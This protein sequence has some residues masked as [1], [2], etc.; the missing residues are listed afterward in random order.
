MSIK[1]NFL[2]SQ[3]L[4]YMEIKATITSSALSLQRKSNLRI[5]TSPVVAIGT[6]LKDTMR[7]KV[8]IMPQTVRQA[9][10]TFKVAVSRAA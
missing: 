3:P 9:A 6:L 1:S 10:D 8:R 4:L 2:A 5:I 7:R